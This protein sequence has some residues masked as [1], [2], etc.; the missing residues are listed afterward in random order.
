MEKAL[1]EGKSKVTKAV[2]APQFSAKQARRLVELMSNYKVMWKDGY[3]YLEIDKGALPEVDRI[4][5]EYNK[6]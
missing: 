2:T 3:C 6:E 1:K 4:M 5:A